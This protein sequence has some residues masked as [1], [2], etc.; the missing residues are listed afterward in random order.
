[1]TRN[2]KIAA[3]TIVAAIAVVLFANLGPGDG[4]A[5]AG[6]QP[7]AVTAQPSPSE[8][9]LPSPGAIQRDLGSIAAAV[10]P[11]VVSISAHPDQVGGPV[12]AGVH[13]LDPFHGRHGWIGSG[14]VVHPAGYVLSSHQVM[15]DVHQARVTMYH[16]GG[17]TYSARRIATDDQTGLVLLKLSNGSA[18]P[19]ARLGDSRRVRTGDIVIAL[20]SP[21]GLAETVTQGIVSSSKRTIMIEGN[22][23][24]NVIQTDAAIN[25]GN[26][27]G[28]LVD[29]HAQVIGINIAIY[30]TDSSFSGVGFAVPSNRALDFI[31]RA[32]AGRQ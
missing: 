14:F 10:R 29:I 7:V 26:C 31:N 24:A 4:Q 5:D 1:M 18:L 12:P 6:N 30:S 2:K 28:P 27:G 19:H 21:F 8:P 13:L 16:G 23:L 17:A 15:R 9:N 11:T 32:I 22:Q 25:S 3:A 20:G